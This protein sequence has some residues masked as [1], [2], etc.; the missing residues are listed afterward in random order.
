[1]F[2][3][4]VNVHG[5][6]KYIQR[7][8]ESTRLRQESGTSDSRHVVSRFKLIR[9]LNQGGL[10]S[11]WLARDEK[12]AAR[13]LFRQ[14]VREYPDELEPRHVI[15]RLSAT[16]VESYDH[17]YEHFETGQLLEM[18]LFVDVMEAF[19]KQKVSFTFPQLYIDTLRTFVEIA[20]KQR[21]EIRK[22]FM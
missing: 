17:L 14:A 20:A 1:M 6:I 5:N 12:L 16:H 7:L 4:L 11:V 21:P 8:S 10:G 18:K 19:V 15:Q 2:L 3:M 9:K 22:F 13:N